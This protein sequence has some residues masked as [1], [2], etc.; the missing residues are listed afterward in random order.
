MISFFRLGSKI[1]N[2]VVGWGN[3]TQAVTSDSC[4]YLA[5][6]IQQ[7]Q[8][9]I[10]EAIRLNTDWDSWSLSA[11]N[12]RLATLQVSLYLRANQLGILIYK[13]NLLGSKS[14]EK[15][16]EGARIAI[17]RARDTVETLD[18]FSRVSPIY[19]NRP[20][21]FNQFLFSALAALFLAVFHAPNHFSQLC[22]AD[23]YQAL[24]IVKRCSIRNRQSRRLQKVIKN[25]K[26]INMRRQLK[27]S[28]GTVSQS[29]NAAFPAPTPLSVS[30]NVAV[31]P[32]AGPVDSNS[33]HT[34]PSSLFNDESLNEPDDFTDFFEL[35][36][37]YLMDPQLSFDTSLEQ[38][39]LSQDET[40]HLQ[41][42]AD[43]FHAE[44]EVFTRLMAG[45][46]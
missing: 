22:R 41:S 45:L 5:F 25:L 8:D 24:D 38:I 32:D 23:F 13:Q 12:D 21:P 18:N 43:A 7:W 15:N 29:T 17:E 14:I 27:P 30:D 10:P 28:A 16:L 36:G 2:L 26:H 34:M 1:W 46:L 9:S 42:S 6:Q 40:S 39:S 19:S 20:Q 35:A 37:G 11:K 4:A 3:S 44:D 31:L 33:V